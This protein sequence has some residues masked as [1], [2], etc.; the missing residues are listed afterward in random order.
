[1]IARFVPLVVVKFAPSLYRARQ[2]RR[3]CVSDSDRNSPIF[4]SK[5]TLF[6]AIFG[7]VCRSDWDGNIG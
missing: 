2:L 7:L 4:V 3:E 5:N 1:M 6:L